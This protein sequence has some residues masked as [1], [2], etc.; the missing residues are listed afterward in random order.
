[1]MSSSD[2]TQRRKQQQQQQQVR[3]GR[4]VW[5]NQLPADQ[6]NSR[7]ASTD[8]PFTHLLPLRSAT[9]DQPFNP[10]I[11]SAQP[12]HTKRRRDDGTGD[13]TILDSRRAAVMCPVV[14][15]HEK[16]PAKTP[17]KTPPKLPRSWWQLEMQTKNLV[18]QINHFLLGRVA[19]YSA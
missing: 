5:L 6:P 16:L 14:V 17:V 3:S 1:M 7:S 13:G 4:S 10:V 15:L 19:L 12:G 2:C 18:L 11:R 9:L 8:Q